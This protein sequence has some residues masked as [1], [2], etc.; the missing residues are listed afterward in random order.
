MKKILVGVISAILISSNA[1]AADLSAEISNLNIVCNDKNIHYITDDNRIAYMEYDWDE[2]SYDGSM[3]DK[4]IYYNDVKAFAEP[5][6]GEN[7]YYIDMNGDLYQY[8]IDGDMNKRAKV[9]GISGCV[10]VCCGYGFVL[11]LTN[12][13]TVWAWGNNDNGQLGNGSFEPSSVPVKTALEDEIV[14]ITAGDGYAY[15]LSSEGDIYLWGRY[16]MMD[17][18]EDQELIDKCIPY[19]REKGYLDNCIRVDTANEEKTFFMT[20]DGKIYEGSNSDYGAVLIDEGGKYTDM[21]GLP[22]EHY[23]F[24]SMLLAE[25][26]NVWQWSYSRWM[27]GEWPSV[28]P[29][30]TT[31]IP[32]IVKVVAGVKSTYIKNDGSIWIIDPAEDGGYWNKGEAKCILNADDKNR[33]KMDSV[34]FIKRSEG[35]SLFA[36]LYEELS[37]TEI[38]KDEYIFKD[39]ETDSIYRDNI[40]KCVAIGL[41]TGTDEDGSFSPNKV[42]RREQA[43]VVISRILEKTGKDIESVKNKFKDDDNIS[44][45]ARESVYKTADLFETEN[46]LYNPQEYVTYDEIEEIIE[47][48]KMI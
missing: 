41:M 3:V 4:K 47:K 35:A 12:D 18:N 7:Y 8:N 34:K 46:N 17:E 15:A 11:A 5:Y 30:K 2:Y 39:V 9:D 13:G 36:E 44:E 16:W 23:V 37:G 10:K 22:W 32:G 31:Y 45:W 14:D 29:N 1:Y 28:I 42:L 27:T 21:S 38:F 24:T 25:D 48:I 26:G 40:E 6:V 20:S 33:L 43:A 19:K